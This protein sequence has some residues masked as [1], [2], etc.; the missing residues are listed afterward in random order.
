MLRLRV[1]IP[2][3]LSNF[4]FWPDLIFLIL[5]GRRDTVGLGP[6]GAIGLS[7][8]LW[9]GVILLFILSPFRIF[10]PLVPRELSGC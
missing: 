9:I 8:N 3:N 5:D 7:F 4:G 10:A 1:S 6:T 2:G